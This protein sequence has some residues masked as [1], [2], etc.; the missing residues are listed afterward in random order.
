[1]DVADN[2]NRRNTQGLTDFI[3]KV[4][5]FGNL[6]PDLCVE[7]IDIDGATIDVIVIGST[8]EHMPYMLSKPNGKLRPYAVYLRRNDT[9]TPINETATLSKSFAASFFLP[10]FYQTLN[11]FLFLFTIPLDYG[12]IR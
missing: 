7:A 2:E 11:F 4:A 12:R 9:N 5:W 3:T 10:T 8:S 1:V 6:W